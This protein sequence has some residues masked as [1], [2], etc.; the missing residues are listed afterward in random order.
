M[1]DQNQLEKLERL[2]EERLD[3]I[4]QKIDN[5]SNVLVSMA[6][7]EEKLAQIEIQRIELRKRIDSLSNELYEVK[8]VANKNQVTVNLINKVAWAVIAAIIGLSGT[9]ISYFLGK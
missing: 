4:E 3:R 1:S 7:V 2:R 8:D 5:L 9:L 6:K